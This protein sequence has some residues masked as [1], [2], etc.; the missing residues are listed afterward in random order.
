MGN[1][2]TVTYIF[3]SESDDFRILSACSSSIS[4]GATFVAHAHLSPPQLL[5]VEPKTLSNDKA[6]LSEGV[7]QSRH[8]TDTSCSRPMHVLLCNPALNQATSV[9]TK[10]G[11]AGSVSTSSILR[12]IQL[13][14]RLRIQISTRI[15]QWRRRRQAL[16]TVKS[17][18]RL[19]LCSSVAFCLGRRTFPFAP[20]CEQVPPRMVDFP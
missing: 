15:S 20:L 4:N 13:I 10:A 9:N 2:V 18:S 1:P 11:P 6:S 8:T 14:H 5:T 17:W 3:Q 7:S 12:F 19:T 16:T